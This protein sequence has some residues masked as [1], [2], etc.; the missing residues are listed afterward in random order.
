MPF[1]GPSPIPKNGDPTIIGGPPVRPNRPI[2]RLKRCA[3]ELPQVDAPLVALRPPC[4]ST[5][6]SP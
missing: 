1:E 2:V 4:R 5:A 6:S 3:G